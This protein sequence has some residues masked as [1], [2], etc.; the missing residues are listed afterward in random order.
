[1]MPA[2]ILFTV[3]LYL[4]KHITIFQ[5]NMI[6]IVLVLISLLMGWLIKFIITNRYFEE[7][8]SEIEKLISKRSQVSGK[9]SDVIAFFIGIIVPSVII[10]ESSLVFTL[11][12]FILLQ[13]IVFF[14]MSNSHSIF[15]NILM[16]ALRMNMYTLYEGLFVL[17]INGKLK[18]SRDKIKLV[19]I[20]DSEICHTY[21]YIQRK[22]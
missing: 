11:L 19:R 12:I 15:P 3:Q 4:K 5:L 20:G 2:Y 22:G 9:N 21:I 18:L 10:F 6:L 7:G 17:T 1:M 16:M 14:L 13:L 8:G